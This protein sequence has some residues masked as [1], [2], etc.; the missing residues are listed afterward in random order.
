MLFTLGI[1]IMNTTVTASK[2][3]NIYLN[4]NKVQ[5]IYVL[6]GG[7]K[8][9]ISIEEYNQIIEENKLSEEEF[10]KELNDVKNQN[11]DENEVSSYGMTDDWQRYDETNSRANFLM[12]SE[13]KRVSRPD[14]NGTNNK[15]EKTLEYNASSTEGFSILLTSSEKN[16]VKSGASFSWSRTASKKDSSKITLNKGEY[17]WFEFTPYKK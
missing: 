5:A 9:E 3:E 15:M 14:H 16:T 13:R 17:G 12:H 11:I 10:A 6:E 2:N 1:M 8:R 4:G 7:I